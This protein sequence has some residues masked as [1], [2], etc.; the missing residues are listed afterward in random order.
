MIHQ[1]SAE[2]D[3]RTPSAILD[4]ST[5]EDMVYHAAATSLFSDG[6]GPPH[7]RHIQVSSFEEVDGLNPT[8]AQA[9]ETGTEI[10]VTGGRGRNL[11]Q[12]F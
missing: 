8:T 7:L 9:I 11:I 10:G 2:P 1:T 6:H 3:V 4:K 12:L 5:R